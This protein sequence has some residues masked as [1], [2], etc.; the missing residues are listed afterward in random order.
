MDRCE[1]ECELVTAEL[2]YTLKTFIY[3]MNH[4]VTRA[5]QNVT[6]GA[7]AHGL[8]MANVYGTMAGQIQEKITSIMEA[9][10]KEKEEE[11]NEKETEEEANEE[12]L[13]GS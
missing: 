8:Y 13:T 10:E 12:K 11:A 9:N 4:W 7:A 2:G 6:P 5:G 3:M 1:E